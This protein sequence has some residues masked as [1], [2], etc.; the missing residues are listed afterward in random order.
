MLEPGGGVLWHGGTWGLMGGGEGVPVKEGRAYL[1]GLVTKT[2]HPG[3]VNWPTI[4][5]QQEQASCTGKA[6]L[7]RLCRN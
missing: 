1:Y 5:Q 4:S 7:S 3:L 2:H 6:F